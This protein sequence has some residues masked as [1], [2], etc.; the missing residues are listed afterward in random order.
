[1]DALFHGTQYRKDYEL[2]SG[3]RVII[4]Y[5][6]GWRAN[7][8]YQLPEKTMFEKFESWAT[9]RYLKTTYSTASLL[10]TGFGVTKNSVIYAWYLEKL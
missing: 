1:M 3:V 6:G 7:Q 8:I 9:T 4:G 10:I 5:E 2:C